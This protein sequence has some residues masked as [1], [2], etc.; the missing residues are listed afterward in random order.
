[1]IE[2]TQLQFSQAYGSEQV[3]PKITERVLIEWWQKAN[4]QILRRLS[5]KIKI[6]K[7]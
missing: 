2:K 5:K 6:K 1:M 3:D 4:Q 7:M